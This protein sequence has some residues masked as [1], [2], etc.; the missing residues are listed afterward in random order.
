MNKPNRILRLAVSL[1]APLAAV[2]AF[3][4]TAQGQVTLN[5]ITNGM[6]DWYP[7]DFVV[8]NGTTLTTPDYIGGRDMTLVNMNGN[9]VLASTRPTQNSSSVSNCLNFDQQA[10]G[11]GTTIMYYD[12]NSQNPLTGAGD[13]LPFCNQINATMNFWIKCTA[14]TGI[15]SYT[16]K[17]FF[18]E[19]GHNSGAGTSPIWLFGTDSGSGFNANRAAHFLFR[20]NTGFNGNP[21]TLVDGTKQLPDYNSF[22]VQGNN[23]T[24]GTFLDGNWHMFTFAIDTNRVIDIYMDGVR[25]TGNGT[26]TDP[27]GNPSYGP[28]LTLTNFYYTT[29]I[30]PPTG[31]MNPGPNGYVRWMWNGIFK[32]GST[33]FGGFRREGGN[34]GGFPMLYDDIGFWNRRLDT[35][36]ITFIYTNGIYGIPLTRPL[37]VS[38]F[39]ADLPEVGKGDFVTLRWSVIGASTASGGIV[40]SGVGDVSSK[41]LIGS[42]NVTLNGNQTFTLTIHN[43]IAPDTNAT[44]SVRA[45]PGVSSSWHLIERFENYPDTVNDALGG[46]TGNNWNSAGGDFSGSFDKWNVLTLTNNGATNKVLTPRTGYVVD[47]NSALG[48]TSRGALSYAKLGSL[49]MSPGQTNTL[50]FRFSLKECTTAAGPGVYSDIDFAAGISDYNFLGPSAGLGY[51]GGTGGGLGPYFSIQRRTL[52]DDFASPQPFDLFAP[53]TADLTESNSAGGFRYTTSIDTNGLATNVNYMV[54]MDV[55]DRNTHSVTNP[56]VSTNTVSEALYSVWLWKQGDPTRTLL[57]TNFHG[58]RNYVGFN[59]VNDN[60]TPSLDRIFFNIGSENATAST[61]NGDERGAYFATNMIVIDDV[62]LSKSGVNGTI[63]RLFDIT[64]IVKG[65]S[66]VTI[67]WDS[68]GSLY[69]TNYYTVQ[70]ATD[71]GS[72]NWTTL[73]TIPSGGATTTYTDSTI[74]ANTTA[75]YRIAWY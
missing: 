15:S 53:D 8:T 46:L 72:Q 42:T 52:T 36:E 10:N 70:R 30:Y 47:T 11:L 48:Y 66:S 37:L 51:Y 55:I 40:I 31:T 45:F 19:C 13:F 65:T 34:T 6:V 69:G 56:G 41:G 35:N 29:N 59:P 49:T 24:A 60:P 63:P 38:S 33:A 27:Y 61:A 68:L 28:T 14:N 25:D 22:W 32:A 9:N 3:V 67:N 7:L 5:Q 44:V 71:L 21:L 43:G 39:T 12:A 2:A 62:Y 54:W 74:G 20:Q 1:A 50:F 16:D 57:F 75:F 73:A 26:S 17:R 64:S 4:N 23:F 58:N 18:G